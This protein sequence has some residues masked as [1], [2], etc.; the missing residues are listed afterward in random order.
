MKKIFFGL[1]I[2]LVLCFVGA[3]WA[4]NEFSVEETVF[5]GTDNTL[6]FI[7]NDNRSSGQ[8]PNN[9]S[10]LVDGTDLSEPELKLLHESDVPI[11][12]V[13]VVDN[14]STAFSDQKK[15]PA[16]IAEVLSSARSGKNDAYYLIS[17]D[18]QVHSPEGPVKF[19]SEVL[20]KLTY[21]VVGESDYTEALLKAVELLNG[22]N[23]FSKKVIILITD[24]ALNDRPRMQQSE[25]IEELT[26]SGYPIYA[27]GLLRSETQS[28]VEA[29][30]KKLNN[31]SESTGGLFFSY[32]SAKTPGRDILEHVGKS[33]V[34]SGKLPENY[35]RESEGLADVVIHLIRNN[36]EM[37]TARTQVN[38][39]VIDFP[40]SD[41]E[42]SETSAPVSTLT[43]VVTV[44]STVVSC[45]EDPSLPE[46]K[47]TGIFEK[48]QQTLQKALG[49]NWLLIVIAGCLMLV[50]IILIILIITKRNKGDIFEEIEPEPDNEDLNNRDT[51]SPDNEKT[52][53]EIQPSAIK[54]NIVLDDLTNRKRFSGVI[55]EGESKVFGRLDKKHPDNGVAVIN[56]GDKYISRNQFMISVSGGKVLIRD[57][58]SSNGTY[59]NGEKINDEVVLRNGSRI[60]IG[61]K[62]GEREFNITISKI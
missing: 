25:L 12:F 58:G 31:I 55:Q 47:K 20:D 62:P 50:I 46:C 34:I 24:G 1:S 4:A 3:G 53:A 15:R 2:L 16:E 42:V 6:R 52:E 8:S 40:I 27:C 60:R 37:T 45:E 14:T 30:L 11:T 17:F 13:F 18:T 56:E 19:P 54:M 39:P 35:T 22:M 33:A 41:P 28:Y 61:D 38:L 23:G 49:D 21:G 36:N 57:L 10:V 5:N 29:D 32:A 26:A 43:P 48:I 51:D 7:I 9:V 59:L 44:I